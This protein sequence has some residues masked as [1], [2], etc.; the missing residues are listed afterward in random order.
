MKTLGLCLDVDGG[1]LSQYAGWDFN[2]LCLLNGERLA[3]GEEGLF[4]LGGEDDA[5]EPVAAEVAFPVTDCGERAVKRL[6][7]VDIAG[8]AR[9]MLRLAVR[10]DDGGSREY[11]AGPFG[12]ENG[13]PGKT[14]IHAGRDGQG[15]LWQVGLANS[16]GC[17]FALS[18]LELGL[19]AL[20]RS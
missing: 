9:G 4:L 18:G 10:A 3:A 11:A 17:D 19:M 8:S 6:R 13:L 7:T 14:R 15:A 20:D 5:G 16:D 12:A 2:S 1:A